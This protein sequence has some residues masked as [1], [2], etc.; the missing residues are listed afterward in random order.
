VVKKRHDYRIKENTFLSFV[1]TL[2]SF[3]VN[4]FLFC[5]ILIPKVV[6]YFYKANLS[7]FIIIRK[8]VT[9][10]TGT[11]IGPLK[12][13]KQ[14][15]LSSD[16]KAALRSI[17]RNKVPSAIS[18]LGLGIGLGCIIILIALISH[19]RS[20]DNYIPGFK[21]VYRITLGNVGQAPY[22]LPEAM[23]GEFPEVKDYFRYYMA[24]SLPVRTSQNEIMRENGFG[25]ADSAVFRILGLKFL[26]GTWASSRTEIA[27]SE[28]AA[29]KY[30][31]N[32][33]PV[34]AALPV[35]FS[36]GFTPLTVTGVF[37]DLPSN[38]TL[39]PS[40]IA[41]IRLSE[42]MFSH[43]QKTLGEY[44]STISTAPDWTRNDFLVYIVLAG[45]ADP[46]AV[47]E[48]MEKYKEFITLNQKNEHKFRL[49]PVREIY[50][51]SEGLTGNEFLRQG[52]AGELLYFKIIAIMVLII[53]L[54]NYILLT[55]AGVAEKVINLGT[56]KAFGASHRKIRRLILLESNLV[57]FIS[58]VPAIFI[59]DYGMKLV[60]TTLNKTLSADVFLNPVLLSILF[61]VILFTGTVSGWLLG[62][63][64][65]KVPA[66][67]LISGNTR[68]K[69]RNGRWNYSFLV[70]HFTIYMIFAAGL[71]AVSKQIEFSKSGFKGINPENVLVSELSSESLMKSFSTIKNEMDRVPGSNSNRRRKFHSSV[72]PFSSDQPCSTGRGQD[73]VRWIDNGG[74]YAGTAWDGSY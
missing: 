68:M 33:S 70:L 28:S 54:A 67:N 27:I 37:E 72:R 50:L 25:F 21:N 40:L 44:G 63:Y 35:K 31:G 12:Q 65:S 24:F 6:K 4:Y 46:A 48:K 3:V 32:I 26:S 17:I 29:M 52:N 1:L 56:R 41:D 71:M 20:F 69:G 18:V 22:P 73:K 61:A 60:N 19:E 74:G 38:S 34:G 14:S 57:V 15:M 66:L 53:S 64:Y 55:R 39:Y 36:D 7:I 30:F 51:G 47:G 62:L 23:A 49:Q 10:K 43:F 58:L 42:R 8:T 13:N 11:K 9:Y 2:V 59:I 5:K 45:N 16:F